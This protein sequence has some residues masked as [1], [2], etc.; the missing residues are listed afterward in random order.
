LFDPIPTTLERCGQVPREKDSRTDAD[1]EIE[2]TQREHN[3]TVEERL[4]STSEQLM[5]FPRKSGHRVYAAFVSACCG[6]M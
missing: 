4:R 6:V 5:T 3:D 1:K 2:R